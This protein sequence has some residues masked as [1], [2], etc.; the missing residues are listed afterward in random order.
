MWQLE[1]LSLVGGGVVRHCGLPSLSFH[2]GCEKQITLSF[3]LSSSTLQSF[4][5]SLVSTLLF[6]FLFCKV[7]LLG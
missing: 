6:S 3:L 1:R 4:S 5:V 2:K 7:L